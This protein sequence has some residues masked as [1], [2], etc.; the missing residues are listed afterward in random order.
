MDHQRQLWPIH[1]ATS[2]GP[3]WILLNLLCRWGYEPEDGVT[4]G[5]KFVLKAIDAFVDAILTPYRTAVGEGGFAAKVKMFFRDN[6]MDLNPPKPSA[7]PDPFLERL[8][9]LKGMEVSEAGP[10]KEKRV[11]DGGVEGS[12]GTSHG[13]ACSFEAVPLA[14]PLPSNPQTSVWFLPLG[15]PGP[16]AGDQRA[17]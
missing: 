2:A 11:Q 8:R 6:N 4:K 13:R 9:R 10:H 5:D 7:P 12:R 15:V 3:A 1:L 16:S 14:F 17:G